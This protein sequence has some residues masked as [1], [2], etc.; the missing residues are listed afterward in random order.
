MRDRSDRC[1]H[2]TGEGLEVVRYDITG[3]WYVEGPDGFRR[4]LTVQQAAT[5]A[6]ELAEGGGRIHFN[7]PGGLS[8]DAKVRRLQEVK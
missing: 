4:K 7:K 2:A 1:V 5:T 6:C 8:F 3:K